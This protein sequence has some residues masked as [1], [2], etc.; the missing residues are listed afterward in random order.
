MINIRA[1]R[2]VRRHFAHENGKKRVSHTLTH[3]FCFVLELPKYNDHTRDLV[4]DE[5]NN[6]GSIG[7]QA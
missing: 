1:S 4:K 3:M 2:R 6:E 7:C 5:E